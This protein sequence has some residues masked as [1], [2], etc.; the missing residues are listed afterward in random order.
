MALPPIGNR[1]NSS[2]AQ[3]AGGRPIIFSIILLDV[4]GRNVRTTRARSS[5]VEGIMPTI[6]QYSVSTVPMQMLF[7]A[8]E[9]SL[10]TTFV[11]LEESRHFLITNWHNLTGKNPRT[12]QHLSPTLAEPDRIRVWWNVKGRLGERFASELPLRNAEG[13]ALWWVH[14]VLG[15]AVDVVALPVDPVVGAD[16]FP[17]NEMPS[18]PTMQ[19]RV[20]HDVFILGYP[21]GIGPSR[22]PIWK[23]G[24]LASEPEVFDPSDPHILVDSASRPG[25][26]GSPVIRRQW[27]SYLDEGG[28]TMMGGGDA[29][30]FLGVYSGRISTADPND[31]QLGL[32]WPVSLVHEIVAGGRTDC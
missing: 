18:T 29:T 4:V 17:I 13:D 24:S 6:D 15:K 16:M 7:G 27:G 22:L 20:G 8:T 23:R 26:S 10:G 19:T 1:T 25:M 28:N 3:E 9:L 31:A 5:R 12:G 2:T 14:P 30:R 11:W 21:F 32:V